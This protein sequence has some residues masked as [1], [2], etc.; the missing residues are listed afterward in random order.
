ML[1]NN[2]SIDTWECLL[3]HR[4]ISPITVVSY[5]DWLDGAIEPTFIRQQDSF[6][7]V[8]VTLLLDGESEQDCQEQLSS[9][10]REIKKCTV[11]FDEDLEFTYNC[12]LDSIETERIV[13]SKFNVKI[14]WRCGYAAG[15]EVAVKNP[16]IKSGELTLKNRGDAPAAVRIEFIPIASTIVEVNVTGLTENGFTVNNIPAG[17][18]LVVDGVGGDVYLED[19]DGVRTSAIDH[20][21]NCWEMPKLQP[22]STTI[23]FDYT[24]GY[25]ICIYYAPKYL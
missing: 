25:D 6:K 8:A 16:D 19:A 14:V 1:I 5:N 23:G 24:T 17:S 22:G 2:K 3:L 18:K 9:L 7:Q 12:V 4:N 11:A 10:T 13:K 21:N 20:Y 15:K